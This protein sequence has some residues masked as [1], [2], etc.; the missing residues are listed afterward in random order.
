MA[1][2]I[3]IFFH[4]QIQFFEIKSNTMKIKRIIA[5]I[6]LIYSAFSYAQRP[7]DK[8]D[9]SIV[10]QKINGGVLVQW[11]ITSDEW[12]NTSYRLYRDGEQIYNSGNSGA[13]DYI[14]PDGTSSSEYVVKTY[15]NDEFV[16][17]DTAKFA[18][19]QNGFI[20][21][22]FRDLGVPGYIPND[23]TAA[24]LDGDGQYEIIIKRLNKDWSEDA[25]HYTL[26]EAYK[27]DGTFMWA[28]DVGPNITMD[29]E[30][31]IA[32]Y[33]FD[34]DGKAEVFMRTSDNTVF[35]DGKSVGDR[36]GDGVTNYRYSITNDFGY[37]NA[38][39]EYLSLIDGETG[40]E[41]DWVNFIPRN[42]SDSWGDGYGHRANKFFF[43]APF[44]DGVHPSLFI[45]RGI[46][47]Q[48]KMVTYDI[49]NKKLVKR[50]S[51]EATNPGN[52]YYGQGNHNYTIAD[53]DGDGRDEIVWGSMCV[54]DNG[55]GLYSTELGHGDA[56]HVGDLDPYRKGTEVFACLEMKPG[57]NLRDGK[58]GQLLLRHYTAKDCG[59]CCCGN[60]TDKY[61]GEEL[62][63]GGY[64][65]S[66]TDRDF[67]PHFGVAENYSVYWD[68]DL[69]KELCDHYNFSK[70]TGVG[71]GEITK[72]I[73]YGNIQTLLAADAYSCN[74]TKGTPCL[75]ADILGDWREEEIWWRTDSMALR[76]YITPYY[77]KHRIY[78][79]MHDHQY[80]QA[81]AW[82]M[83]GYNQ[84]PH[85]SFYLGND[86]PV[87]IPAKST[88]GKYLWKGDGHIW[89]KSTSE[90]ISGDDSK[91]LYDGTSQATAFGNGMK[92]LFDPRGEERNITI[93]ENL[94]P[95]LLM[96]SDTTEYKIGVS[97]EAELTGNM[98][99]DKL[100]CGTFTLEGNHDFT[101]ETNVWEGDFILKGSLDS[102]S[103]TVRRH[104]DFECM[105]TVG[106]NIKTEYGS[107]VYVA[108]KE[109]SGEMTVND[110]L[111]IAEG[112]GLVFDIDE[113]PSSD[114]SDSLVVKTLIMDSGSVIKI[115][116]IADA[117]AEA[118]Y[119]LASFEN[120]KGNLRAIKVSGL[121][122][123]ASSLDTLGGVLYLKI[124]GMRSPASVFWSGSE[125]TEW[126]LANTQN[127]LLNGIKD[128][129]VTGDSVFFTNEGISKEITINE[130]LSPGYMEVNSANNYMFTCRDSLTG[131][132]DLTLAG[133]G[134]VTINGKNS[135]KGNTTIKGGTKLIMDYIPSSTSN[136]GIGISNPNTSGITMSDSSVIKVTTANLATN[137]GITFKTDLGGVIDVPS[138]LYWTGEM[139]GTT[140]QKTGAGTLY[141]RSANGSLNKIILRSGTINLNTAG[142]ANLGVRDSFVLY[143]GILT[144]F[145]STYSY[146]DCN[147]NFIVP[148][149]ASPTVYGAP[150]CEYRGFLRGSGTLN[151]YC[152]FIRAYMHGNWSSFSGTLNIY[153]NGANDSY[154]TEF[155]INNPY[156]LPNASV[157][158]KGDLTF[159]YKE[160]A[161]RSIQI[162]SLA[163][164]SGSK[165]Y[166]LD[167]RVGGNNKSTVFAGEISGS[168]DLVKQ[169]T[170]TMTL[171]GT[172]TYTGITSVNGGKLSVTGAIN[173][174]GDVKVSKGAVLSAEGE[175]KG[176]VSVEKGDEGVLN[177][178]RLTG[179]GILTGNVSVGDFAMFSPA[180]SNAIGT[181]AIKGNL[182]LGV[183]SSVECQVSGGVRAVG[184]KISVTGTLSCGGFLNVK[185]LNA[186][187]LYAG[188]SIQILDAGKI[189]GT[190][191]DISLPDLGDKLKWNIN[192]LYTKGKIN[193]E[194]V[195]GIEKP[196]MKAGVANNPSKGI[197]TV[198]LENPDDKLCAFVCNLQGQKIYEKEVNV[199]GGAFTI[200]ISD[201]PEG[202]YILKIESSNNNYNLIKLMKE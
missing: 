49:V 32:A 168:S 137:R 138:A 54:D 112:A 199:S 146:L 130:E 63:G 46:Y 186:T 41:L 128:A 2:N 144:T 62:W 82:Q 86:F 51:W 172:N 136:G 14:D 39:P 196:V 19:L 174:G 188:N 131:D 200:D 24:D 48:T 87:P 5:A 115:N 105:G 58:T 113:F 85:A 80:R 11:R 40:A 65:F 68:G 154:G 26:F 110:T 74:Y 165:V 88:N 98:R 31:N 182:S 53:V 20:D 180:D 6:F 170:G 129:F 94:S 30:I 161:V 73:D 185:R 169:G 123:S 72:F 202:I 18:V 96:V 83:C 57:L 42:G 38:G 71:Y 101:G 183:F 89:S 201:Q 135:F 45:G 124:E 111:Q 10:A 107:S 52:P 157:N 106:A 109:V 13:S 189:S 145:N 155:L 97:G 7:M 173:G 36:D 194:M 60:I 56:M 160:G 134:T 15:H 121:R 142:A 3:I 181:I 176:N 190:F 151:W 64:G 12:Y 70:T 55:K 147:Y 127:W 153:K 192:N 108:G 148:S 197:F 8:L 159:E 198:Y 35:G 177:G 175:I 171:S 143:G 102:S 158:L 117:V 167:L 50:W 43:G 163:G 100:G 84:P 59:R 37:M 195:N 28:I 79:L 187:L 90:W 156:G 184:D 114:L 162:G 152:D 23:A 166:N 22:K 69:L 66:A 78:T 141:L 133:G 95:E 44:L 91:S 99:L 149:G 33:D 125:N 9:R 92:V 34:G 118:T 119:P 179:D 122:G 126:D 139:A 1:E 47:T 93:T 193:V 67:L 27:L 21:L 164:I 120:F 29:V 116:Q 77:T 150:R 75:Q 25:K 132:M 104:A 61:K 178:G 140:M 103:V 4:L 16:K 191:T 17:S 81:I 76:I